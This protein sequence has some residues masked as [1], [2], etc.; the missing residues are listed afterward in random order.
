[1][2]R[3]PPWQRDVHGAHDPSKSSGIRGRS[4]QAFLAPCVEGSARA[5]GVIA[6]IIRRLTLGR[7]L[8]RVVAAACLGGR[9]GHAVPTALRTTVRSLHPLRRPPPG[10]RWCL[11]GVHP[12]GTTSPTARHRVSTG[13]S[14]QGFSQVSSGVPTARE[15]GTTLMTAAASLFSSAALQSPP[16]N[17]PRPTRELCLESPR[18]PPVDGV[19]LSPTA[20]VPR[21]RR[22]SRRQRARR[23]RH[24]RSQ[25]LEQQPHPVLRYPTR[26][27]PLFGTPRLRVRPSVPIDSHS[28]SAAPDANC[29]AAAR[30]DVDYGTRSDPL[31]PVR[32]IFI[33]P[34]SVGD[35]NATASADAGGDRRT[36]RCRSFRDRQQPSTPIRRTRSS[37]G[38]RRVSA[39]PIPEATRSRGGGTIH[40]RGESLPGGCGATA[41][42][43]RL[44]HLELNRLHGSASS[45]LLLDA[46]RLRPNDGGSAGRF[47]GR[48]GGGYPVGK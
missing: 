46:R 39:L 2:F 48:N 16:H 4:G 10:P 24:R 31:T 28:T 5:T 22:A 38:L 40:R 8:C 33:D 34:D 12:I 23:P 15:R 45:L 21:L 9:R 27:P 13:H 3:S 42:R 18:R 1:M 6:K 11:H 36:R 47:G 17:T 43:E 37:R 29:P 25:H 44:R 35:V 26:P 20:T 30:N 19:F 7:G 32:R 41:R 14:P